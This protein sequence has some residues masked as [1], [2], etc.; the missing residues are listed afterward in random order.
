MQDD[1]QG[2]SRDGD[3]RGHELDRLPP[4][5]FPPGHRVLGRTNHRPAPP[6]PPSPTAG[7]GEAASAEVGAPGADAGD[8][9]ADAF[10]SPDEPF[11]R[12][13]SRFAPDA[14]ISPDEPLPARHRDEGV[15]PDDVVVTGIG[16]DPHLGKE[17]A[18][19]SRPDDPALAD[20]IARVGRLADALR[21]RGEA[22]L[23]TTP[24][25]TRFEATLRAYCVGYLAA[26]REA[27]DVRDSVDRG[28]ASL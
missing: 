27:T 6:A 16:D 14:F 22:G 13:G 28:Q 8:V 1:S 24:D 21:D 7:S 25:M 4:P 10:I 2:P 18:G 15:D 11:V 3:G 12:A 5:A 17:D 20:L 9:P 26:R 19:V 23:R